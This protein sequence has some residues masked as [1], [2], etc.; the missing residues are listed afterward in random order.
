MRAVWII[1]G[2]VGVLIGA[3]WT[4][5]GLDIVKSGAM[6]GNTMWAII[7]PIVAVVG[8]LLLLYG[9]RSRKTTRVD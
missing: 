8:L 4:L 5:Q 9:S 6:A 3:F 1:F 7:G 2:I